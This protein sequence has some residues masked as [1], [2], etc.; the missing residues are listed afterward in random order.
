LAAGEAV[1]LLHLDVAGVVALG[2]GL[3]GHGKDFNLR[4][5]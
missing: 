1:I 5:F 4:A 2:F 3:S